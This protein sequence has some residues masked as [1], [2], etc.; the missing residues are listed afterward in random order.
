MSER[1]SNDRHEK[2]TVASSFVMNRNVRSYYYY[3]QAFVIKRK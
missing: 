2:L 1:E 3:A